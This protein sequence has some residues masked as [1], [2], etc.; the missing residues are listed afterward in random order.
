MV[1]EGQRHS[2]RPPGWVDVTRPEEVAHLGS[3]PGKGAAHTL[4]LVSL[5]S[6]DLDEQGQGNRNRE[7]G[8]VHSLAVPD[9]D[10]ATTQLGLRLLAA[11]QQL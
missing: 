11:V 4:V 3:L 2:H 7:P 6:Q 9:K 8:Y 10:M 5:D 1:G